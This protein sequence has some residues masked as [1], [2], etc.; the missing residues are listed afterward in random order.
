MNILINSKQFLI[1]SI[2]FLYFRT[3]EMEEPIFMH[4]SCILWKTSPEWV[5][6]QE[7]YEINKV[8][9][10]NVTAIE[11]EWLPKFAPTLCNL[12]EPLIDPPPRYSSYNCY[13]S[14][15]NCHFFPA[16]YLCNLKY[17]C[18]YYIIECYIFFI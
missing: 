8:Y 4:S 7:L 16:V 11:P 13:F 15:Y 12:S 14:Y 18:I 3:A 10:R 9:M 17:V 6:Y 2:I 1:Y 5:V